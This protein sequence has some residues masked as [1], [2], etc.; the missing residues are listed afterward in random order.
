MLK[1]AVIGS[2]NMDMVV[3]VDKFPKPGETRTGDTFAVVPGGK[4]A[5]QAVALGRLG[6]D[7]AMAGCIGDDASGKTYKEFD[8]E[9]AYKNPVTKK[10]TQG[11]LISFYIFA[12]VPSR[13]EVDYWLING[14]KYTFPNVIQKFR[15]ENLD[16]ATVYEVVFKN[17][18]RKSTPRPD[19]VRP[20][21]VG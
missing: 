13:Q 16:E 20:T 5:N 8:F 2:V 15:V 10:N 6:G 1:C 14:V 4:G 3:R 18:T 12:D 21:P 11:G 9:E 19:P 7:V 17:Q